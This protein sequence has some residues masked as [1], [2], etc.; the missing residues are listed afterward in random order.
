MPGRILGLEISESFVAAVQLK[1]GLKGYEVISFSRAPLKGKE[2]FGDAL[3]ELSINCDLR[4]DS[5]VAAIPTS[6]L[7][8]R[9]LQMPFKEKKKIAQILPFEIEPL[10]PFPIKA[11]CFDFVVIEGEERNKIVAASVRKDIISSYLSQLNTYGIDPNVLEISGVPLASWL[12]KQPETPDDFVLLYL[13]ER[14]ASLILG[15]KRHITL[16]RV[17]PYDGEKLIQAISSE[18]SAIPESPK[19]NIGPEEVVSAVCSRIRSTL[20]ANTWKN[21]SASSPEKVY[22]A[23]PGSNC[24][25]L[26]GLFERYLG[27]PVTLL[28]LSIDPKV[29]IAEDI[30]EKWNHSLMDGALALALRDGKAGQGFNFRKGEFEVKKHY[31]G[32]KRQVKNASAFLSIIAALLIVDFGIDYYL[33]QKKYNRLGQEMTDIFKGTF[34]EVKRFV[35]PLQQMKIKIRELNGAAGQEPSLYGDT[36]VL[37]LLKD[38]SLRVPKSLMVI[39][40]TMTVDDEAVR[41]S[42]KTDN[43]NNVDA[44]KGALER[45]EFFSSVVIS[46]ANLDRS[47][48]YVQ[49]E[50]KLQRIREKDTG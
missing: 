9:N 29:G 1:S 33:L 17:L 15:E 49:F 18:S 50:L 34:P 14:S 36:M 3:N 23:G 12:I 32:L 13:Q 22:L 2:F 10:I 24:S 39:I 47:G 7:S 25:A 28:D 27:F 31:A 5:C 41:I 21:H 35:D 37:D 42:G 38:I 26:E 44:V 48:K 43:F 46:A 8:Y 20:H 40:T 4:S 30:K 6:L 11:L 16:I 45:S 19:V